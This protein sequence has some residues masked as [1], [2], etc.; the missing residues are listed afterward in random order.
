MAKIT[1]HR[2]YF[3]HLLRFSYVSDIP[4]GEYILGLKRGVPTESPCHNLLVPREKMGENTF[5][6]RK[7]LRETLKI[8][9]NIPIPGTQKVSEKSS[10]K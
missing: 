6:R 10:R 5:A 1:V 9:E 4:E 3:F 7:S 8:L 2:A